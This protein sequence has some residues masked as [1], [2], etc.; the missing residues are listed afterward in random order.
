VGVVIGEYA[1]VILQAEGV[2]FGTGTGTIVG[3]A[4]ADAEGLAVGVVDEESDGAGLLLPGDLCGGVVGVAAAVDLGKGLVVVERVVV[5][6]IEAWL[7]RQGDDA[8]DGIGLEEGAC[9]NVVEVGE[10]AVN[11]QA[12]AQAA[13]VGTSMTEWL[14]RAWE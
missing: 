12:V 8:G 4:V 11:E 2:D 5:L 3:L 1:V 6:G 13:D 10:R 7:V 14:G 9:G